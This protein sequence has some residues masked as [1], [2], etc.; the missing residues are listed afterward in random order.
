M[1]E[2]LKIYNIL[3]TL[4]NLSVQVGS[5]D[6]KKKGQNH[7]LMILHQTLCSCD[8]VIQLITAFIGYIYDLLIKVFKFYDI[9]MI[10]ARLFTVSF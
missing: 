9:L 8:I 6:R 5:L 7:H 4:L 3:N 2:N 1:L 10:D